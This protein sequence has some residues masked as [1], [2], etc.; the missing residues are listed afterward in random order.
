MLFCNSPSCFSPLQFFIKPLSVSSQKP[1]VHAM[2]TILF[3]L[4]C[5]KSIQKGPQFSWPSVIDLNTSFTLAT[6]QGLTHVDLCSDVP[7]FI[8]QLLTFKG[9][10]VFLQIAFNKNSLRHSI[11]GLA[12]F[13]MNERDTWSVKGVFML[14]EKLCHLKSVPGIEAVTR[15]FTS[16]CSFFIVCFRS[17]KNRPST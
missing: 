16:H 17:L 11:P 9:S 8:W 14:L 15:S 5:Q 6:L 1:G 13:L 10:I 3:S 2:Q 12:S 4:Q 7:L